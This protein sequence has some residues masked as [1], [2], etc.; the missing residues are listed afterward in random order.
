MRKERVQIPPNGPKFGG[1]MWNEYDDPFEAWREI[2]A[3]LFDE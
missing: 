3:G 1:T 2:R